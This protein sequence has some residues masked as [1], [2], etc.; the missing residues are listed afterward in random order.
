MTSMHTSNASN[1]DDARRRWLALLAQAP[2][3]E[4][5]RH[6]PPIVADHRFET[7]R[8][9]EVGLVM[10]R[11]RIGQRGDRYNI[12]EATITRCVLRHRPAEPGEATAGIGCVLGRDEERARWVAALD[13]LLQVPALH[14]VLSTRLL[15]PLA[16]ALA[17]QRA[18]RQAQVDGSRVRFETLQPEA[19]R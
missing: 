14:P 4:L 3:A 2:R 8:A 12:G 17:A 10:L 16:I 19:T 18:A 1:P 11:S 15:A 5:A 9:P 6:A 7:L 13:A